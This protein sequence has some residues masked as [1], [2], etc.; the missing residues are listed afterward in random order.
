MSP[1]PFDVIVNLTRSKGSHCRPPIDHFLCNFSSSYSSRDHESPSSQTLQSS[2]G[3]IFISSHDPYGVRLGSGGG[4]IAALA[5]AH[6]AYY[7]TT[8]TLTAK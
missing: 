7:I 3:T 2:D 1:Y 4:T 6:E 8:L 5:E